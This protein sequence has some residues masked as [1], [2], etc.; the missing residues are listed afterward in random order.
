MENYVKKWLKR[1]LAS[2]SLAVIGML[3]LTLIALAAPGVVTD[4]VAVAT[5]TTISLT[6]TPAESSTSGTSTYN[7]TGSYAGLTGLTA[8]TTYYFSAWGYDGTN[9]GAVAHLVVT[10]HA[11]VSEN[12][13]IPYAKPTIV[14]ATAD[15][16]DPTTGGWSI[17]PIDKIL[18]YFADPT[19]AHGG[20]GMPTNNLVM[21]LTG[22]GVTFVGLS[23]YVKWRSF[24][25]SWFIVLILSSF[26]AS[27]GVMQWITVG[28]LILVGAGV[29]AIEKYAQ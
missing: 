4:L 9:Y 25:S 2:I 19:V 26:A 3:C 23:T 24:F 1:L 6:W 5:D 29:W 11:A 27:I 8:G 15:P 14:G 18:D 21:F 10:T 13:T 20:L 16:V 12:T 17:T 28:F 7:G 22:V